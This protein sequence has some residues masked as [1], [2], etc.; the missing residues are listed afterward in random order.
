MR[1][2]KLIEKIPEK[3]QTAG[4]LD[5]YFLKIFLNMLKLLRQNIDR[6]LKETRKVI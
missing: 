5:K 3:A 6:E 1:T 4:L 2:N